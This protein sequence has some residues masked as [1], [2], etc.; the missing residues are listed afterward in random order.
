MKG[1]FQYSVVFSGIPRN[2]D[3]RQRCEDGWFTL[4]SQEKLAGRA[5]RGAVNLGAQ[6]P[7]QLRDVGAEADRGSRTQL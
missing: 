7:L 3:N 1:K 2:V 5:G 4:W 6:L